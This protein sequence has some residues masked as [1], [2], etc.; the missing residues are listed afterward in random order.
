MYTRLLRAT[1]KNPL[2]ERKGVPLSSVQSLQERRAE[3]I[4]THPPNTSDACTTRRELHCQ[5]SPSTV[6]M[7]VKLDSDNP[8]IYARNVG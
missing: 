8:K 1:D 6:K 2:D 4:T 7:A 5:S 3:V